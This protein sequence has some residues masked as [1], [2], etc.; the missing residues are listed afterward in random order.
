MVRVIFATAL[1]SATNGEQEIEL[2]FSGDIKS[3]LALLSERY[4]E[5]FSKRLLD[6]DGYLKRYVNAYLDGRDVRFI[7]GRD[8]PING[9]SEILL[10]PAVSGG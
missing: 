3:L 9:L 7:K 10:L 4:G 2:E 8:T 6:A 5:G 1:R